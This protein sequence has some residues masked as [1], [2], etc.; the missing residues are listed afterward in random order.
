MFPPLPRPSDRQDNPPKFEPGDHR[1]NQPRFS[2]ENLTKLEPKL[3]KLKE[4]FGATTE[5]LSR[6]ALQYLLHYNAVGAVIPGFRNL[7]Q[8]KANLDG[9]DKSLSCEEFEFIKNLF[10]EE[11]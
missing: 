7:K 11:N 1:E 8:V 10:K 9:A 6:A 4:K 5:D 3:R 2:V